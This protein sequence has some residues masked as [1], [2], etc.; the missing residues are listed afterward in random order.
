MSDHHRD[1][2]IMDAIVALAESAPLAPTFE[3][4]ETETIGTG[5]VRPLGVRTPRSSVV[6]VAVL[7]AAAVLVIVVGAA[8]LFTPGTVEPARPPTS[9]QP[10]P[11]DTTATTAPDR[12]AQLQNYI[13]AWAA[14]H[15]P[16]GVAAAVLFPGEDLWLGATGL[17]DRAQNV[18]IQPD[19]RFEVGSITK[20][21]MSALTLR[22]AEAGVIDLD[23]PIAAHVDF[24]AAA[25]TTLRQLLGHRAGVFDPTPDLVSDRDGPPDPSKVFTPDELLAAAASGSPTFTP[26]GS[27]DYS[28]ANYWVLGAVLESATGMTVAELLDEYV[29]TPLALDD[30]LLF[31]ASLPDTVLV[32]AYVDLDLDGTPD[33]MGTRPLSGFITPAWTAGAV[34]SNGEDLV[35]FLSALF[36]GDLISAD[37]LD[38]ML[39]VG[40]G[41]RPSY[42]L[43]IYRVGSRWGHDGGIAGFLAAVYHDTDTGITVAALTN[44]FGP[45]APQADSLALGIGDLAN[46]LGGS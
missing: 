41:G 16:V 32:N 45:D 21:F 9:T 5:A 22:L 7:A 12:N 3:E 1:P 27:H 6:M 2:R 29:L 19:D 28:N 25:T 39:D 43:G 18:P 40:S 23:A 8:F 15:A 35:R 13:D 11:P 37:S 14:D 34:I 33:A 46:E 24:H 26:G 44:R 42:A 31:D 38:A 17:A 4:V 36:A 20:T 30:T 10:P